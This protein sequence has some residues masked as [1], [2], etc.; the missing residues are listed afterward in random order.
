[1]LLILVKILNPVVLLGLGVLILTGVL[2]VMA[3][4]EHDKTRLY[5]VL[6]WINYCLMIV[7]FFSNLI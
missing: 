3:Q 6:N 5:K 7:V 4:N 2:Q 1:M